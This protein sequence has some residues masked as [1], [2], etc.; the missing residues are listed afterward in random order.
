[1]PPRWIGFPAVPLAGRFAVFDAGLFVVGRFDGSAPPMATILAS[2][3]Y[4]P[5]TSI[6]AGQGVASSLMYIM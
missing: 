6:H 5:C 4:L 3:T 2:W 1:M